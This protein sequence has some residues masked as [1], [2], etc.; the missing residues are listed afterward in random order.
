MPFHDITELPTGFCSPKTAL[1][2]ELSVSDRVQITEL[3][4][5]TKITMTEQID[6]NT[7]VD[8]YFQATQSDNPAT[9]AACFATNATVDDPVGS[10]PI[11]G[12]DAILERGKEF[13]ANFQ[14]VG[15]Y[16]EYVSIDNFRAA[17][18]WTG[19]GV[20]TD[21]RSIKFEGINFFEFNEMG[22]IIK[23][24]GFWNPEDIVEV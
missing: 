2:R 10:T 19:Q 22:K 8:R 6:T 13:I 14:T 20:T 1:E 18:K 4:H 7:L 16:P 24:V 21:A 12:T 23:L 17:A 5:L 9:W 11:K 15:L 3:I